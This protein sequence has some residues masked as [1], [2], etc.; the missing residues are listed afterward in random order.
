MADGVREHRGS[1]TADPAAG[2]G[3]ATAAEDARRLVLNVTSDPAN[4]APTRRA[5]E[6]FCREIG[7][8]DA[9]CADVG[10]C[11]NEAM[12]NVTRH[13]YGGAADRPVGVT[14]EETERGVRITVRDWGS[15]VNPLALPA[16]C[17]DPLQPG[18]LGLICLRQLLDDV[19]FEPQPDGMLLTMEKRKKKD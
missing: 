8:D 17:R 14:A 1:A 13:A 5:C 3:D 9:A 16:R 7:L 15:G 18:G 19:R 2:G 4:L 10:L 12:A 6:A 11:V